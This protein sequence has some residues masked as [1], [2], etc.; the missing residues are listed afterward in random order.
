MRNVPIRSR[1]L[2]KQT[3]EQGLAGRQ[4]VTEMNKQTNRS[5]PTKAKRSSHEST[6]P[7]T[8]LST[9]YTEGPYSSFNPIEFQNSASHAWYLL[10][11][12]AKG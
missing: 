7:L 5:D 8:S 2:N 9:I 4:S 11:D 12:N 1:I 10:K 6:N 3:K